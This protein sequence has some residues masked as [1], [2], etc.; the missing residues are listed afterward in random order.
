MPKTK[1]TPATTAESE[2]PRPRFSESY[3]KYCFDFNWVDKL[4][5][6][7]RPLANYAHLSV[8]IEIEQL[9]KICADSLLVF[10]MS[11]SRYMFYDSKVGVRHPA[12]HYDYLKEMTR[13]GHEKGMATELFFVS[14]I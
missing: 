14:G 6:H 7:V 4:D 9:V 8:A 3:R 11:I 13:L 1:G 5:G 12:L 10:C 2:S